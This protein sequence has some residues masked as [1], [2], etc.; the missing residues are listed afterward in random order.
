[1]RRGDPVTGDRCAP[2][3][4]PGSGTRRTSLRVAV[5]VALACLGWGGVRVSA[6][7]PVGQ[8]AAALT[9]SPR[10][11]Q[12][13]DY[14]SY[15]LLAPQTQQFRILYDVTA[16]TPGAR[17]F[18]NPIRQGSE[19]SDERVLDLATGRPLPFGIVDGTQAR[20]LGIPDAA[21]E[22]HYLRIDLARP[23]PAGGEQRLRI[24]KTYKDAASYTQ[25]GDD[26]VFAR[27]LGIRRNKVILPRGYELVSCNTPVQVFTDDE[28]RVA[29]SF[30]NVQPG[31][32]PLHL[33]ARKRPGERP[34]QVVERPG[35]GPGARQEEAGRSASRPE[36]T[37]AASATQRIAERAFQ[38]REITYWLRPPETHAFDISHDY[39]E[40]RPGTD[41][42]VNVVR[43]GSRV[44][45]PGAVVLD[46]GETLQVET[47]RG[48]AITRAGVDIGGA[49]TAGSEVVL[50]RFPPVQAG[51]T[52]R[53]RITET[54]T[55][56]ARYG[57]VGDVLVWR[58]AF[59]R[60]RN[61]VVL[62]EGWHL[63]ANAVPATIDRDERGRVRL[64]YVNPR[65][66]EIDVL[67]RA[68]RR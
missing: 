66:D 23:V 31:P 40:A 67:I 37:L 26:I 52:T 8:P 4:S 38:D 3:R 18:L 17:V 60:P 50:V 24:D 10:Q 68:E 48:E 39:T 14:T 54:Y 62:P 41:R 1:M 25:D 36:P 57:V 28:G 21:P 7:E 61:V 51:R 35:P 56:P 2:A 53:L 19:A 34:V 20:A 9:A 30:V 11:T 43:G 45:N 15:E 47:L 63:T 5:W 65:N 33:R 59:G 32:V 29:V 27:S 49:V 42:Y 44:S 46:T 55:D 58:R 12:A 6:Q 22:A 16:T 13:D 64:S